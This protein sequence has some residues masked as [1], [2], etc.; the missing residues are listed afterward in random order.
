MFTVS[1]ALGLFLASVGLN[2]V[3]SCCVAKRGHDLGVR[4]ALTL[5]LTAFAASIIPARRAARVDPCS[6]L[7]AE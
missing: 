5:L 7:G 2:S 4:V 6:A 3:V 1:G